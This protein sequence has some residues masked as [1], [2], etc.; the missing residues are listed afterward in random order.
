MTSAF[1]EVLLLTVRVALVATL[2][3]APPCI[4][5][6]YLLARRDF[7]GK[8]AIAAL[9][10][11]PLVVPPTAIGM[12]LLRLF[13]SDGPLGTRSLGV[14]LDLVLT[15]KGA[16]LASA[17][18]CV[19]LLVRTAQ[20]AFE[21]VDPE[22]EA[23]ARTLGYGRFETFMRFT[24]PMARRGL[25]AAVVL[26]FTRAL[27]EYGATVTLAGSIPGS[28]RT[29]ASAI[30]TA[31]QAGDADGARVLLALALTLG[32]IAVFVAERLGARTGRTR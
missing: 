27:G 13:A 4:A 9:A 1:S 21:A 5:L 18:M 12:L 8:H 31:D 28:T 19:P 14:D 11:L 25:L 32:F 26:G 3:A 16:A 24:V 20:V 7:P 23:M 17:L 10:A 29:L 2:F 15:W 6:G 30:T 22:L